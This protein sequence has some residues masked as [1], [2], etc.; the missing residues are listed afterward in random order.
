MSKTPDLGEFARTAAQDIFTLTKSCLMAHS[1]TAVENHLE[2]SGRSFSIRVKIKVNFAAKA[3]ANARAFIFPDRATIIVDDSIGK[4]WQRRAIAHE[5][6]HVV[7]AFEEQEH[8]GKL[9]RRVDQLTEDACSIFEK[10]LC[11]RHHKYNMAEE[12]RKEI[13]FHTLSDHP[14]AQ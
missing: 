10:D 4:E 6:G 2:K 13:L 1:I 9:A 7:V 12:N 3:R 11:A 14:L 8:T 5:L